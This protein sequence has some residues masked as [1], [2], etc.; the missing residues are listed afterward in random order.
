MSIFSISMGQLKSRM[1]LHEFS[2][3]ASKKIVY[4]AACIL[5]TV[6]ASLIWIPLV[7]AVLDCTHFGGL[8]LSAGGG[9]LLSS[10]R[11]RSK[12]L[13][14][15]FFLS[16]LLIIIIPSFSFVLRLPTSAVSADITSLNSEEFLRSLMKRLFFISLLLSVNG[17]L[18]I[19]LLAFA[20]DTVSPVLI[21]FGSRFPNYTNPISK[22][23]S[24]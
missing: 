15:G 2:T 11:W 12:M 1:V 20:R 17:M 3:A 8:E 10:G 6:F 24:E 18:N 14:F 23:P 13:S 9:V 19:A 21:N 7:M 5:N 4:L 16:L 22:M